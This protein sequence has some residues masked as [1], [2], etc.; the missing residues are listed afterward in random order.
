[1]DEFQQQMLYLN[2]N[3]FD[4]TSGVSIGYLE[5]NY[6][7]KDASGQPNY[8]GKRITNVGDPITDQD[9]ATKSYVD[10]SHIGWDFI[11]PH[12]Y[13]LPEDVVHSY[14]STENFYEFIRITVPKVLKGDLLEIT[15]HIGIDHSFFSHIGSIMKVDV[16]IGPDQVLQSNDQKASVTGGDNSEDTSFSQ[17][18]S[19]VFPSVSG[20][21]TCIL[22]IKPKTTRSMKLLEGQ[23]S[24]TVKHFTGNHE[25]KVNSSGSF[26]SYRNNTES[27]ERYRRNEVIY[28]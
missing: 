6:I 8:E 28:N 1:M 16:Y 5:N 12:T 25:F 27:G 20:E 24:I 10:R 4:H 23:C 15:S 2:L 7:R 19:Y 17:L 11:G 13:V 21:C 18:T 14:P 26:V 22:K 9:V 3:S